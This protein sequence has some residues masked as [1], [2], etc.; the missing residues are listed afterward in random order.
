MRAI[1]PNAKKCTYTEEC[2]HRVIHEHDDTCELFCHNT[3]LNEVCVNAIK[4]ERENKLE[5]LNH[6]SNL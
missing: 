6:V 3:Q 1:C 5:K 4:I 2:A